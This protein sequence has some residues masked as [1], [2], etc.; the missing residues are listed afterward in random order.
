M[1]NFFMSNFA[2]FPETFA[3]FHIV[4]VNEIPLLV[5]IVEGDWSYLLLFC[6][7]V[8]IFGDFP[9]YVISKICN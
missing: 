8:E 3:I 7:G 9:D 5:I 4:L 6:E 1:A 2:F